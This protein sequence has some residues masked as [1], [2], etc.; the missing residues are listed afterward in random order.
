MQAKEGSTNYR[1]FVERLGTDVFE[2]EAIEPTI[3]QR[4]LTDAIEAVLD[5]EAFNYECEQ[6][7]QDA[8]FLDWKR[9]RA[10]RELGEVEDGDVPD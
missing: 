7:K 1:R 8:L 6:E 3:L 2:L 9:R 10:Y 5:T 4:L